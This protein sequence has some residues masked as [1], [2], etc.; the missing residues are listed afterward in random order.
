MSSVTWTWLLW[1]WCADTWVP[2]DKEQW[3]NI[4]KAANKTD[5]GAKCQ[6]GKPIKSTAPEESSEHIRCESTAP[7]TGQAQKRQHIRKTGEISLMPFIH[8]GKADSLQKPRHRSCSRCVSNATK[9]YHLC[10]L[11]RNDSVSALVQPCSS[12]SWGIFCCCCNTA[13]SGAGNNSPKYSSASPQGKHTECTSTIPGSG[14]GSGPV[15][16][17]YSP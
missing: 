4:S 15:E 12:L 8:V 9:I 6:P 10:L 7:H 3:Q 17:K 16:V 5:R 14:S 1:T 2:S 11:A 13:G